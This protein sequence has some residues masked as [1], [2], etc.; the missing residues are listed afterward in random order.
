MKNLMKSSSFIVLLIV[1]SCHQSSVVNSETAIEVNAV[2]DNKI[3]NGQMSVASPTPVKN[4]NTIEIR[5]GHP[6]LWGTTVSVNNF[7]NTEEPLKL[8]SFDENEFE[9]PTNENSPYYQARSGIEVDLMNCGGYLASGRIY[10]SDED[11]NFPPPNWEL[12][13]EAPTVVKDIE[14]KI[15]KCS[16]NAAEK[17]AEDVFYSEIF[18]VAPRKE[19]RKNITIGDVDTKKLFRSLPQTVQ[20]SLNRKSAIEAGRVKDDLSIDRDNWTDLDGD[21]KIDLIRVSIPNEKQSKG[22]VLLFTKGKWRV[23]AN[24]QPM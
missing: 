7:N 10:S 22:I 8:S 14:S 11:S 23:I 13:I 24:T 12:K 19:T 18:A 20:N 21:G 1:T 3:R 4:P 9:K 5:S 15:K 6:L 16:F 17:S 2:S